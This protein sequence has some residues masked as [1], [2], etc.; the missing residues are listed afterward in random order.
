[1]ITQEKLPQLQSPEST[2]SR[3]FMSLDSA[4]TRHGKYNEGERMRRLCFALDLKDDPKIIDEYKK[5]HA[6]GGPPA[7]VTR[8]IRAAGIE[9]LE[10]YLC[11]NRLFM[12]MEV[13]AAFSSTAKAASDSA[14]PDVQAWEQLM[15]NFQQPLPWAAPG[16]KWVPTELIYDLRQH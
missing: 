5:W 1:M 7:A 15:W 12:I 10:I 11:G 13:G 8:S 6:K 14:D 4:N 3:P 9:S 16:Q 2:R